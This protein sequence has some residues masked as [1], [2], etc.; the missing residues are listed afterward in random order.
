MLEGTIGAGKTTLGQALT[1]FLSDRDIPVRFLPE[2]FPR[3]LLNK[4][5][6]YASEFPDTTNIYAYALQEAILQKRLQ[7]YRKA[8]RLQRKGYC[9]FVD[10]SL[11]GDYV[12]AS[13]NR[14]NGNLTDAEWRYYCREMGKVDLLE[15]AAILYL[16]VDLA[17]SQ[18]RIR[19]RMRDKETD[20]DAA[21]LQQ[22]IDKYDE[23]ML[24]KLD[25]PLLVL[26]WSTHADNVASHCGPVLQHLMEVMFAGG[27]RVTYTP[28]AAM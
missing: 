27:K 3:D 17:T 7:T 24:D 6:S 16:K 23:V 15:P 13:V 11:P 4:Y 1:A 5:I 2:V 28:D 14:A 22:L 19:A 18:A 26:Q 8:L 12:F 10:R 9:V 21:Y 25:Y 20:Y